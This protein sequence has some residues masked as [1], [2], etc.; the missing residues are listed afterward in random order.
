MCPFSYS[1]TSPKS[2]P[3]A[4]RERTEAAQTHL[5]RF[6]HR[7]EQAGVHYLS[8]FELSE[9]LAFLDYLRQRYNGWTPR[10][11]ARTVRQLLRWCIE[12]GY[13]ASNPVKSSDLPKPPEPEPKP[14]TVSEIRAL[15]DACDRGQPEWI[16]RRNRALILTAVDSGLRRQEL[17]QMTVACTH[18]GVVLVRAKGGRTHATYL[19]P[20]T[21]KE[22]RRYLNAFQVAFGVQLE[23]EDALWRNRYGEPLSANAVRLLLSRLSRAIR[24]RVG[25]HRLRS[26]SVCLRLAQSASTELIRQ[27]LGHRDDQ[28]LKHYSRLA[29]SELQ[30]LLVETSP[31]NLLTKRR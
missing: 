2:K 8:D 15:L 20:Q 27:A 24:R 17:L 25:C 10:Q 22:L 7:C 19:T 28:S 29:S 18:S 30:R 6:M 4:T 26:T 16:V 23:P 11:T 1:N 5:K 21:L 9:W 3:H 14:L 12:E 13:L 31:L